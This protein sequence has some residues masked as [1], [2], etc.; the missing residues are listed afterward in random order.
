MKKRLIIL[1]FVLLLVLFV[2]AK[3]LELPIIKSPGEIGFINETEDQLTKGTISYQKIYDQELIGYKTVYKEEAYYVETCNSEIIDQ[4]NVTLG[5]WNDTYYHQVI[6]ETKQGEPIYQKSEIKAL[7]YQN[8]RYDFIEKGCSICEKIEFEDC[9]D[10]LIG[11]YL[12]CINNKDGWQPG[13]EECWVESGQD[14]EVT[15]LE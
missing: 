7:K 6:D 10:P 2:V 4:K 14:Y 8:D 9:S 12:L 3:D 5:C 1:G 11:K 15:E 13:F